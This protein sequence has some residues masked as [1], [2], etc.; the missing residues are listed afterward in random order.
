MEKGWAAIADKLSTVS[1]QGEVAPCACPNCHNQ[2]FV[3]YVRSARV[4]CPTLPMPPPSG[5]SWTRTGNHSRR[6]RHHRRPGQ[7][8]PHDRLSRA[9]ELASSSRAWTM[10]V[11]AAL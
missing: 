2:V 8:T 5:A 11:A 10:A 9:W 3:H 1:D 6:D 4:C 7:P